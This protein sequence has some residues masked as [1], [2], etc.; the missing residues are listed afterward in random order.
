MPARTYFKRQRLG[1][2]QQCGR[3]KE[4]VEKNEHQ[5]IKVRK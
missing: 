1:V 4:S 3:L 5:T 2:K